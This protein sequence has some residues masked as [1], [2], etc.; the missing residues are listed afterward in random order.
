MFLLAAHGVSPSEFR[1]LNAELADALADRALAIREGE[2]E[3]RDAQLAYLGQ[4]IAAV[5]KSIGSLQ[6]QV[7]AL[8]KTVAS[9]PSI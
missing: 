7:G 8:Q 4:H 2:H 9:R 1:V 5:I 6:R 3:A